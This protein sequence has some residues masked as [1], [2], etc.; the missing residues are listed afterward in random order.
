MLIRRDLVYNKCGIVIEDFPPDIQDK[1]RE[2]R[3][4]MRSINNKRVYGRIKYSASILEDKLI[5]NGKQYSIETLNGKHNFRRKIYKFRKSL[6][7]ENYRY[8][9]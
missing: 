6:K 2:L 9:R 1:R 8:T 4:L 3:A 5:V 7:L